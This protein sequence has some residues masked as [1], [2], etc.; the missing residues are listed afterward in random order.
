MTIDDRDAAADPEPA[1]AFDAARFRAQL[2]TTCVVDSGTG[3]IP[4]RLAKVSDGRTG[5]G[6]VRFSVLFDG[7]PERLLVQG[8]YTFHHE[9]LGSLALFIVPVLGSD[10]ERIVYE[11]CFSQPAPA[12]SE[13]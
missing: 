9:V 7:P 4:M 12:R 2:G 13:P 8:T 5:G 3:N 6:F 10:A 1:A 11:A